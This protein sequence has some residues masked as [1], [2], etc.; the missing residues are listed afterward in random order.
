MK[1]AI[2]DCCKTRRA[3]GPYV[4][5]ENGIHEWSHDVLRVAMTGLPIPTS[6]APSYSVDLCESCA[7]SLAFR[8]NE[9]AKGAT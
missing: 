5:D 3:R 6:G 8:W 7:V 2:C 9:N 1:V 4:M